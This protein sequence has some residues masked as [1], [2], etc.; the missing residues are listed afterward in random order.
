MFSRLSSVCFAFAIFQF[1]Q[2]S[3][4]RGFICNNIVVD[5][6]APTV[7]TTP[8]ETIGE[9]GSIWKRCQKRSVFK[10]MRFYLSCKQRNRIDLR[11]AAFWRG[12]CIVRFK[13][14]NLAL[15]AYTNTTW[16]FWPNR[17]RV[18]TSKPYR[19]C[20]GFERMKPRQCESAFV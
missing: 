14:V 12:I 15:S 4:E 1:R 20:S 16:I 6:V 2:R 10:T 11:T 7:Y 19:F 18:K 5:A 8:T 17:F 3:R 13:M 9:S